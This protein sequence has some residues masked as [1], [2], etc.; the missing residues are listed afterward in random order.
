MKH[1]IGAANSGVDDNLVSNVA[2]MD[3]E[4]G[5]DFP[6]H[7]AGWGP[8]PGEDTNARSG[9]PQRHR[10]IEA[11]ESESACDQRGPAV[12][13]VAVRFVSQGFFFPIA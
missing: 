8:G 1:E 10:E 12:D 11:Q 3:I 5:Q 6:R 9:A 4:L 2:G 13:R 7:H